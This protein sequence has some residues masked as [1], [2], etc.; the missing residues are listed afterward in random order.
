[1]HEEWWANTYTEAWPRRVALQWRRST[2]LR[3]SWAPPVVLVDGHVWPTRRHSAASGPLWFTQK[4]KRMG[5][6]PAGTALDRTTS[7][8][9]GFWEGQWWIIA[10]CMGLHLCCRARIQHCSRVWS[11][12]KKNHLLYIEQRLVLLLCVCLHWI[13]LRTEICQMLSPCQFTCFQV[14]PPTYW[15][16]FS[17]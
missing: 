4:Q 10:K 9:C 12:A 5:V 7:T 11:E 6:I 16:D 2:A 3:F 14:V 17:K 8:L 13:F 15:T 1:M